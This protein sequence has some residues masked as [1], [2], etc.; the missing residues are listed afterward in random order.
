MILKCR[1]LGTAWKSLYVIIRL[2][3][4]LLNAYTKNILKFQDPIKEKIFWKII[5][6]VNFSDFLFLQKLEDCLALWNLLQKIIKKKNVADLIV[7]RYGSQL[8][9]TCF[10]GNLG[11]SDVNMFLSKSCNGVFIKFIS[12]VSLPMLFPTSE[13]FSNNFE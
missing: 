6:L 5:K 10:R 2:N 1:I 7:L 9:E 8:T 4:L 11:G 12:N 3:K 13:E